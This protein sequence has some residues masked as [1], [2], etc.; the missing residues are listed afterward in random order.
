MFIIRHD[1]LSSSVQV[2]SQT[3]TW[4]SQVVSRR[5]HCKLNRLL[6]VY[7]GIKLSGP[8]SFQKYYKSK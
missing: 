4:P 2:K 5:F 7:D 3:S 8:G 1:V 6:S